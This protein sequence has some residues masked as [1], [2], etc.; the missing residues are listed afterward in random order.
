MVNMKK[1]A[2][3]AALALGMGMGVGVAQAAGMPIVDFSF[4]GT[5]S[6]FDPTGA[7]VDTGNGVYNATNYTTPATYADPI[8]G[9]MTIDFNN[10]VGSASIT[11][12]VAFQGQFWTAHN[13]TMQSLGNGTATADML[14]DWGVTANIPVHVLFS[15]NGPMMPAI[16]DA[17]VVT[18]LDDNGDGIAGTPMVSGPF[19]NFSATFNG[20]ATVTN[21]TMP[22]AVPVPAA[23]WLLGSGLIGLVGVARRRKAA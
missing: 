19:P 7:G 9:T 16:G 15:M 4:V 11:P 8:N 10:G 6:M 12:T 13:I 5:F 3:S 14:F 18:T 23:A 2:I 22:A 21:M 1:T 20:T 17:Y